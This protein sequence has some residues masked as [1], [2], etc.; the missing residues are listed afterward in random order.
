[1]AGS[2]ASSTCC[3]A[4]QSEVHLV[5]RQPSPHISYVCPSPK[6][7]P[8]GLRTMLDML[9]VALFALFTPVAA[10]VFFADLYV[11]EGHE[12]PLYL[13]FTLRDEDEFVFF[14]TF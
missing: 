5:C 8:Y 3:V 6:Y 9:A 12:L 14:I 10:L 13:P 4:W 7:E 2:V 1:M 11:I